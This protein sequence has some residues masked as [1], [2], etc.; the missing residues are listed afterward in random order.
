[1][2][3]PYTNRYETFIDG[4]IVN[5][6]H[7]SRGTATQVIDRYT[8]PEMGSIW[9]Q[10]HKIQQWLAV[11]I[12]VCEAWNR[13]DRIPDADMVA[14]RGA[15]CDLDRM[16][17]I[18]RETDHDVI[19][20]L[21]A[22]AESVGPSSRFI[23]LGLT[24]SDVVDTGLAMQARD[25]C[26]VLL[27]GLDGLIETVGRR[28]VEHKDTLTIGR[29]HGMHAE[30]TTFG[31]KLAVWFDE[32]RRHRRRLEMARDDIAVGQISGAVG[33]HAHVPP[34]LEEEVCRALGLGVELASTQV[35]QRDRHAFFLAVL[36]GIASTLEKFAVE[37]RHL[38]RSEVNEAEEEFGEGNQGSSAMPHKRNPHASERIA[39]L[40]RLV[41]NYAGVG[42]ENVPLWHE[43]D[44]SHSSAERVIFPDASIV[45]DF[46][47]ASIDDIIGGLVVYPDAM[48]ANLNASGGLIYSQRV[49]LGLVDGGMDRQQ[50][51]KLV[52]R[53]AH[54]AAQQG[55]TFRALVESDPDI[56]A[57]LPPDELNRIF[58]PWD[59]LGNIGTTFERLGLVG[60]IAHV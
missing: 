23:H 27:R 14:I 25:A 45:L 54:S 12:A 33:T 16:A 43:R 3:L 4:P 39:G 41:R 20:F 49:L 36:A 34:D 48:L 53:Y 59:Q 47:L 38:Q 22:T 6:T 56:R 42:F 28:A 5:T 17:E 26:D 2:Q 9:S 11:E 10:D 32:L 37:I 55:T 15:T 51:Y 13:R 29:S 19:A 46:M 35:V 30:P 40:A 31:L 57:A 24:S 1:M 8:R 44:I 52:Q 7:H 58:D 60:E 18:E 21:R 50:A